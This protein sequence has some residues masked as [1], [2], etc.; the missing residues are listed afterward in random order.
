MR[1]D[2]EFKVEDGTILRGYFHSS[3]DSAAPVIVMAHNFSGVK[4]Q[5]DPYAAYFADGGFS[6]LV[7]DHRGFGGSDGTPRLELDASRQMADWRDAISFALAQPE[8]DKTSGVGIWGSSFAGGL[9]MVVAAHDSRVRCVVSQIPHVSGHRNGREMFNV[10][11][12]VRLNE[13]FA[14]DR[15]ARFSGAEPGRIP[16]FFVDPDELCALPPAMS[17][18]YIESALAQTPSWRN[19]V[20]L[21]SLQNSLEFEPAGWVRYISPKPFLM[22]VAANDTCTFPNLQLD[23]FGESK[24]PKRLVIHPGGHFDTYTD[25]FALTSGAALDW[26]KEHLSKIAPAR[27]NC[28]AAR[29]AGELSQPSDVDRNPS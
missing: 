7:H 17:H 11:Q 20:T 13:R 2:V 18:R 8:V 3:Q 28:K 22:I 9:A 21:R 26:F 15:V 10:A 12:R 19:E 24:E 27:L 5:I 1:R 16:V 25:H 6:V 14:A 23:V 4:E 29:D